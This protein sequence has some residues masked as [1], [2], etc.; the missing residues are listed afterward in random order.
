MYS[1]LLMGFNRKNNCWMRKLTFLLIIL[2]IFPVAAD[3]STKKLNHTVQNNTV[4]NFENGSY[5]IDVI[6]L[7]SYAP[8]FVKVNLTTSGSAKIYYIYE[9][10]N[11]FLTSPFNKIDIRS[12]SI[13]NLFAMIAIDVPVE[14]GNP[15]QYQIVRPTMSPNIVLTK[16]ADKTNINQGEVVSFTIKV[17]NTGNATAYNLTLTEPFPKGFAAALGKFPPVMADKLDAGQSQ[18]LYYALKAVDS[19]T[20]NI[21]PSVVKY[22]SKT[23]TS[24]SLTLTVADAALEKSSLTTAISVDKNNVYTD[25]VIKATVMITNTGNAATKFV[26]IDFTTPTGMEVIENNLDK[27]P[28][29]IAPGESLNYRLTLKANE[30]G[31]YTLHLRTVYNDVPAGMASDSEPIIVTQNEQNYLYFLVPMVIIIAGIVLFTI[32]RHREYSY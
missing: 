21:E 2:F 13:T 14:W 19:G 11:P 15:N 20:F 18:E 26:D 28:D 1:A 30:A 12:S 16:L 27:V 23:S 6:E 4:L 32:K 5:I 8:K 10:E 9:S 24:N 7:N 31:N 29:S 22:G 25:D 3:A 17:E